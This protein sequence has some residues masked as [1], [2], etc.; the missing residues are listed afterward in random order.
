[1]SSRRAAGVLEVAGVA[2]ARRGAVLDA[3]AAV[4]AEAQVDRELREHAAGPSSRFSDSMVMRVV[5]AALRAQ[6]AALHCG[7]PL[8]SSGSANDMRLR[9]GSAR[10]TFGYCIGDRGP[11]RRCLNVVTMPLPMP[12]TPPPPAPGMAAAS[13][14]AVVAGV[15]AELRRRSRR[16]A[17]SAT[18]SSGDQHQHVRDDAERGEQHVD[19]R[20]GQQ[21]LPADTP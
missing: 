3:D 6:H 20:G 17:A 13:A 9:S 19:E 2:Q 4:H 11:D 21:Q 12:I 10:F 14:R 7:A 15:R 18:S 5:R 1:M 8:S 16:S